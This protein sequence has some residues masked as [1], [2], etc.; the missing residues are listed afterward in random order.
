ME[1]NL[2]TKYRPRTF[3][4]VIGQD[5]AVAILRTTV[6]NRKY[7]SAYLLSGLSGI[8]KTTVGRIFAKAVLCE[9]PVNGNPCGTCGSCLLFDGERHFGYRELDAATY[10]GKDDMVKLRDDANFLST[11]RKKILLL[12]ECHDIS[13]QGQDA[14]LKQVE[15]CPEHLIYIF[16]T[17]EPEKLKPTLRK[18]CMQFQFPRVKAPLIVERLKTICAA[19]KIQCDEKA[20]QLMAEYSEGH[21]RDAIKLLEEASYFPPITADSVLKVKADHSEDIFTVV[22]CLGKDL[23]KALET[24]RKLADCISVRE[25]YEQMLSMVSDAVKV[26]YGYEDFLPKRK[27]QL[28]GLRDIHGCS[29]IEFLNYLVTRERFIDHTGLQSDIILIHYKFG[30]FNAKIETKPENKVEVPI[31]PAAEVLPDAQSD[32]TSSSMAVTQL[33]KLGV[34]DRQKLLREQ[35]LSQNTAKKEDIPKIHE[36]WSLPKEERLGEDSLDLDQELSPLEFSKR[37]VGGR[38]GES[39]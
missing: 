12:D 34:A 31:Q 17:T 9:N 20:V 1:I 10:G 7:H 22:S 30:T 24:C 6:I 35:K 21:V 19:E 3:D 28:I 26:I 8:G 5:V 25:I 2:D 4:E 27:E 15:Q 29:L 13:R 37:M 32:Q 38:G 36:E 14:L 33:L 11:E 16:C 39:V 23:G 18:R